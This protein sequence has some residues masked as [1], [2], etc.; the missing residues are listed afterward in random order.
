MERV[1]VEEDRIT[2]FAVATRR[3]AACSLCGRWSRRVHSR[4]VRKLADLPLGGRAVQLLVRV[5]RFRCGNP[6]CRRR[7]FLERFPK[8]AD[9]GARRT[10]AER[11]ALTEVGFALGGS[12]GERLAGRLG[13]SG[14]RATILRLVH[15]APA[16][17][18]PTPRV[19]GVDDWAR[20]RGQTYGTI[21]VDLEARRPVDL[22]EDRSA[23][24]FAAWLVAHPGVEI[25]ARDRGGAYADGAR[26][27]APTAVQVADRF[28][29][30]VNVGDTLERVLA[31][32]HALLR[33][34][35]AA[36]D[37]ALAATAGAALNAPDSPASPARRW[38]RRE[39]R[40]KQVRRARRL[41]RY[42]AVV[43]LRAGGRRPLRSHAG[44]A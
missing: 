23:D 39:D 41:E 6:G 1:E 31:R 32:K 18:P 8:L 24:G 26:R 33:E 34:A 35:A 44:S 38:S 14:S 15:A 13:L 19:L 5:R 17:T 21:L 43:A 25:I 11:A 36:V 16:P 3:R 9:A 2:I 28:H 12:A 40:G 7:I 4:R 42:E 37:R 10:H 22:L 29:L 20:K 27:G 30:L